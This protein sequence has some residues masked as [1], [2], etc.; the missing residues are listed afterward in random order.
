MIF[1]FVVGIDP[2]LGESLS[3]Y[4]NPVTDQLNLELVLVRSADVSI[5]LYD[6][7]GRILFSNQIES[8]QQLDTGI[9]LIGISRGMYILKVQAGNRSWTSRVEKL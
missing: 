5:S 8:V 7:A 2:L 6:L 3:V 4:P 1:T 9:N